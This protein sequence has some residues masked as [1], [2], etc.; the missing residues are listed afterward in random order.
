[1]G[2][3]TADG[4]GDLPPTA[5][6]RID[7]ACGHFMSAWQSGHRPR[8]EEALEIV[9]ASYSMAL[10]RNLLVLELSRRRRD[11]EAP[12]PGEYRARFPEHAQLIDS[13][14]RELIRERRG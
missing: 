13:L 3:Q 10:L 6:A 11:G 7:E 5:D 9:P 2:E 12:T 14:F 4:S 8:I 1:M